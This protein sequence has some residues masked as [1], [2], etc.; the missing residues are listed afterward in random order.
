MSK[1]LIIDD[2]E[3][4][5]K[6]VE[7][8]LAKLGYPDL[9]HAERGEEGVHEISENQFDLVII[10]TVLPDIDGFEV[11]RRIRGMAG[12]DKPKIIIMTGYVDVINTAKANEVGADEYIVK[13][14]DYSLLMDAVK[15]LV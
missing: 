15:K 8:Q 1:I 12:G 3:Q 7:R 10:D 13:T 6:I 5:R 14:S 4:H 9:K 2:D 11:C